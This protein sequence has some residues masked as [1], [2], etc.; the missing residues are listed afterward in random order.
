MTIDLRFGLV[1]R[2]WRRPGGRWI[3]ISSVRSS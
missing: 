3:A 1:V 2:L